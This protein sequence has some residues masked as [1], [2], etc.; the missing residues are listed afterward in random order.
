ME[1]AQEPDASL[2]AIDRADV[3]AIAAG[4]RQQGAGVLG[5]QARAATVFGEPVTAEG[6]TVIP[7]A[8]ARI[9]YS[10]TGSSDGAEGGG[11]DVRAMGYIE[12]RG[13]T[14]RYRSIGN[15]GS[16]AITALLALASGLAASR[17][18]RVL[19]KDSRPSL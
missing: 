4:L 18:I 17:I 15:R 16:R 2:D 19:H 3:A 7:V 6:I 10:R 11:A 8:R 5:E 1:A 9:G 13:G 14:A 12:I